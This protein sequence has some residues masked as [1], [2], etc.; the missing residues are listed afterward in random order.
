MARGPWPVASPAR[1]RGM[2]AVRF[3]THLARRGHGQGQGQADIW[4]GASLV[5]VEW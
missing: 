1:P 4:Y 2:A 5:L 3:F